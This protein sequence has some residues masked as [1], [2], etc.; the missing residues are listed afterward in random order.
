MQTML[1]TGWEAVRLLALLLLL[2]G[3][4]YPVVTTGL[5]RVA[6]PDAAGGSLVLHNGTPIGSRWIGQAWSGD[7]WFHGRPSATG[8]GPYHPLPSSGSNLGPLNPELHQQFAD[9]AAELRAGH[10]GTDPVPVELLTAS[11][12]G[13]DPHISP[14]GAHWQARRVAASRG[15]PVA[16]VDSLITR[17]TEAPQ[18]GVLGMPR[19]NVLL[20][21]LALDSIDPE[22]QQ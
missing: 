21:N 4:V 6:F 1:R 22:T 7:R 11:A 19:V 9:R 10:T 14:A 5:A 12:S 17:H 2:T 3:V 15:L 20:L 18:F 13:L 8:G 16:T